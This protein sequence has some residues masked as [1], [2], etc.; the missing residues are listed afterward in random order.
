MKMR[1]LPDEPISNLSDDLLQS[2]QFIDLIRM[3][4]Q[5][6]ETPFVYGVLGDWGTGKTSIM[7][8]LERSFNDDFS[9][10]KLGDSPFVPIWFN[11]WQYENE[12]NVVYP[13][14]YAIKQDYTTRLQGHNHEAVKKSFIKVVTAS[15]LALTDLGL[16]VTTKHFTGQALSMKD[17]KEQLEYVEN[18]PN[19]L[20]STL[21]KWADTVGELRT[22]FETLLHVYAA[23]LAESKKTFVSD[24]VRF[25]I[26]IDDLD[27]CLP[28]T[29]ITILESIK[30]YL[31]VSQCVFILGINPRVVYDGIRS[32]Y[33]GLEIDGREYLEK[34]LNYSFH[35]PEPETTQIAEFALQRLG[36]LV[37][38]DADRI[39]HGQKFALFGDVLKECHFN[40]PRKI[41][42]ILNRYLL[43]IGKY[44]THLS[45]FNLANIVRLTVLGEYFPA[46]FSLF[47]QDG[48][49]AKE[50][51][52][53]VG[54]H[55][56]DVQAFEQRYGITLGNNYAQLVRMRGLFD[57]EVQADPGKPNLTKQAEEV[58]TITRVI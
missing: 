32:K 46:L 29:V 3:A 58:S 33:Q 57:L 27:R 25:V 47:L 53:Q 13:L 14:L 56:F 22:A 40:N 28:G 48:D 45:D 4:T 30:N 6:T 24:D 52:K 20:E 23:S 12:T 55:E 15:A 37:P 10:L 7:R 42:R 49:S 43:F 5:S 8:M 1:F 11:A 38:D 2:R 18:Q 50:V 54:S 51:L 35:V 26:F 19:E 39:K 44:E 17:V 34:I 36:G 41:K 31:T 21:S 16:R 9:I